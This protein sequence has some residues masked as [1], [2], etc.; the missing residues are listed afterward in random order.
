MDEPWTRS[1]TWRSG[2]KTVWERSWTRI[3][4]HG[5]A[6]GKKLPHQNYRRHFTENTHKISLAKIPLSKRIPI[7]DSLHNNHDTSISHS[8]SAQ[9]AAPI[10]VPAH[11]E[12]ME[13]DYHHMFTS[14]IPGKDLEK[15]DIMNHHNHLDPCIHTFFYLREFAAYATGV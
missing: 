8:L 15:K 3:H 13:N 7:L 1:E 6:R 11:G 14:I 12:H 5:S 2:I 9:P 4:V 10:S